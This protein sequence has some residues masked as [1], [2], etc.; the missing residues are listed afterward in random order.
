MSEQYSRFGWLL[1]RL[2]LVSVCFILPGL[3][4]VGCQSDSVNAP[5]DLGEHFYGWKALVEPDER[6]EVGLAGNGAYPDAEWRIV[7]I[8]SEIIKLRDIDYIS[9]SQA[10]ERSPMAPGPLLSYTLHVFTGGTLGESLLVL[11]VEVDGQIVD[12]YQVTV[13]VV[14]DACDL[15]DRELNGII[16]AN[17]CGG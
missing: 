4:L 2:V 11:E 5:L 7:E 13:A 1:G 6:F 3:L 17:R 8:D 9:S 16:A 15:D 14:E 12:R 10:S